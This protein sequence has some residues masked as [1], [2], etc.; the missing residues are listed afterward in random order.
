[1]NTV[2]KYWWIIQHPK[3]NPLECNDEVSVSLD[4]EMQ[5]VCPET[6]RIESLSFLNTKEEV[7]IEVISPYWNK[8]DM[9]WVESHDWELDGGGATFE[10]AIDDVYNKVKE[11]HGDVTQDE[12]EKHW[13]TMY[14]VDG[15]DDM[16]HSPKI[17]DKLFQPYPLYVQEKEIYKMEI[18]SELKEIEDLKTIFS[19]RSLSRTEEIQVLNLINEKYE[20]IESNLIS[21]LVNRNANF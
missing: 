19:T 20:S 14:E 1:M 15:F 10:E 2:E 17:H 21:L 11:Q 7:W 13:N 18:D 5:M 9:K 4:I 6:K 12:I 3:L 16:F 8:G